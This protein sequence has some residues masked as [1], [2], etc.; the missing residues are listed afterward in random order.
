M[1]LISVIASVLHV[2][3]CIQAQNQKAKVFA[4]GI[5]STQDS[6]ALTFTPDGETLYFTRG[7]ADGGGLFE[8]K[9]RNGTW[10]NPEQVTFSSGGDNDNDLFVSPS[11]S[12]CF[13]MSNRP[14]SGTAGQKEQDIWSVQKEGADWGVPQHL[15]S[16]VNS[17]ARDG[18]PSVTK[19]GTL[20]FFS[21]R[22]HGYGSS[23]IYRAKFVGGKYTEPENIGPVINTKDWD[24]LP[25]IA[26]DESFLILFSTRPGGYGDGDLYVSYNRDGVWTAPENLGPS[27]N[28]EAS[29]V[30]PH[31]SPDGKYLFFARSSGAEQRRV[32]YYIDI[33]ETPVLFDKESFRRAYDN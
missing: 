19:D 9:L 32:I 24:G 5:L 6:F 17:E 23:D 4:E 2:T 15:G 27:V 11:G 22:E 18:F 1:F 16:G 7:Q 8:S 12:K 21:E 25:Y 10:S 14:I 28:T 13:F 31:V 33:D 30:T 20:Y 29:E 26:P 3:S